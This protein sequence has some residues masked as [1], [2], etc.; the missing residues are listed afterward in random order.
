M[1]IGSMGQSGCPGGATQMGV[2]GQDPRTSSPLCVNL[3]HCKSNT[4]TFFT[5]TVPAP[6]RLGEKPVPWGLGWGARVCPLSGDGEGSPKHP[7][8]M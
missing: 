7:S 8:P 6:S 4:K 3:T 2:G 1:G 5:K